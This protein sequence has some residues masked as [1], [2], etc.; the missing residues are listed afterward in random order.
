MLISYIVYV[1]I[2]KGNQKLLTLNSE[3]I[4]IIGL[5][6]I[7]LKQR[8]EKFKMERKTLRMW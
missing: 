5:K 3:I 8:R 2:I 6:I 4:L 1:Y 7:L